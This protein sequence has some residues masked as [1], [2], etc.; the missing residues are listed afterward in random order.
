MT[1]EGQNSLCQGSIRE[2]LHNIISSQLAG[3][4]SQTSGDFPIDQNPEKVGSFSDSI[5]EIEDLPS[6]AQFNIYYNRTSF[7]ELLEMA[8][9]TMLHDVNGQR[10]KSTESFTG[11]SNQFI[12]LNHDNQIGNL[13]K[14]DAIPYTSE[15]PAT[16]EYTSEVTRNSG[17]NCCDPL[18]IE[19]D[20]KAAVANSQEQTQE[21]KQKERE[22]DVV[23]PNHEKRKGEGKKK[24]ASVKPKSKKEEKKN[25]DWDS[26]RV[27]AQAQAG[28]RE[29]TEKTMDSVD[30]D[31]VRR[32]DVSEISKTIKERG[33]NNMLAERIQ[34][35]FQIM[36]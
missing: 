32:A 31:A 2:G 10:S 19:S 3:V 35:E 30:W 24:S 11:K 14:S 16:K 22:K 13:E 17:A 9:S 8:S 23:N 5:S 15:T 27:Q 25:F 20:S 12:D 36:K 7:R 29:K 34:V 1:E 33:M 21:P 28:K 6:T 26:L 4:V 18:T